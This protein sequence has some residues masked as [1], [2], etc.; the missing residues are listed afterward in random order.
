MNQVKPEIQTF[1]FS[2]LRDDQYVLINDTVMGGQSNSRFQVND[3]H[4]LYSGN[5][6]LENN[7]GFASVRMLW[8]FSKE[9][10]KHR[11][12]I[13]LTVKGD[14]LLYQ[15]RLRTDNG[16]DGAAY[17]HTFETLKD[18][19]QTVYLSVDDFVPQFRGRVLTGMPALKLSDV[20]QMGILIA[21]KQQ[22][23][24]SIALF[25]LSIN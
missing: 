15:F 18:K 20:Q 5:I 10:T 3:N 19:E 12:L 16:F 13:K 1:Q 7:G 21:D 22:G 24:F 4:V 6:S 2:E 8:P 11:S 14:G 9:Q 25:D 17:V 23:E